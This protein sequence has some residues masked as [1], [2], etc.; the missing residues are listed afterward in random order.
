MREIKNIDLKLSVVARVS[1]LYGAGHTYSVPFEDLKEIIEG[2]FEEKG[3]ES[4]S[5]ADYEADMTEIA[6]MYG[7]KPKKLIK[8]I[9][10]LV[11]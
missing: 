1:V 8:L 7:F 5:H 9:P 11:K 10:D 2:V 6:R 4:K 3:L